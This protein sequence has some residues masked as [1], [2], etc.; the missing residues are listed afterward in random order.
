[1]LLVFSGATYPIADKPISVTSQFKYKSEAARATFPVPRS[2]LDLL[3][4]NRQ[5]NDEAHGFFYRNDLVFPTPARLQCFM[6]SLGK[7]RLDCLRS[8]TLFSEHGRLVDKITKGGEVHQRYPAKINFVYENQGP[9]E[10]IDKMGV[11]MLLVRLLPN[12]QKLHLMHRSVT[13]DGVTRTHSRFSTYGRDLQFNDIRFMFEMRNIPD[14]KIRDLDLEL[15][16]EEHELVHEAMLRSGRT[17]TASYLE[18]YEHELQSFRRNNAAL[19]H[20]NHGLQLAQKGVVVH[21]LFAGGNWR[22]RMDWPKLEGSDCGLIKG[23]SCGP[24]DDKNKEIE[25][26]SHH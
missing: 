26:V 15:V 19:K 24:S 14:I 23:C 9:L 10:G 8:L 12:L 7:R 3:L 13:M 17:I 20:L 11:A 1:M 22:E 4:V 16:E 5:V 6:L 21:E 2:A 25:E 18:E